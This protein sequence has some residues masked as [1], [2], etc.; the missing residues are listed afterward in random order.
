MLHRVDALNKK[1]NRVNLAR[2][3][4]AR[5]QCSCK[6]TEARAR[7]TFPHP[8]SLSNLPWHDLFDKSVFAL[9]Q[10]SPCHHQLGKVSSSV[11]TIHNGRDKWPP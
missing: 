8:S 3:V 2:S 4:S 5:H 9:K 7:R 11:Q 1:A 6:M 10:S